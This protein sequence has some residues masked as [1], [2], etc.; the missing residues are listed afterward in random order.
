M[1]AAYAVPRDVMSALLLFF[2]SPWA[3]WMVLV[4]VRDARCVSFLFVSRRFLVFESV[5]GV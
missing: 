2:L 5:I 4:S 1:P 3:E